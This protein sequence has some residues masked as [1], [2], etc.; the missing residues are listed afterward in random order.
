M[1]TGKILL[2]GIAAGLVA[3]L[4]KSIAEPPLQKLGLDYFPATED[5][6]EIKGADIEGH[7]ENMPPAVLSKKIT[8]AINGEELSDERAEKTLPYIHYGLGTVIGITYAFARNENKNVGL[9]AGFP[10]GFAV[11]ALTHG[12]AVPALNLQGKVKQ[13]PKSWWLWE[14][15]SHLLFGFALEQSTKIFKKIL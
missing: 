15:G 1:K 3:S 5:E 9:W 11:F 7:P 10:A 4:I 14:L 12:T 13:M 6:L 2:A 8:A